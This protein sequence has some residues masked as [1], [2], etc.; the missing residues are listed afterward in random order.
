MT[1]KTERV[2]LIKGD[3]TKWYEQAIFILNPTTQEKMPL[4][5]VQEAEKIINDYNLKREAEKVQNPLILSAYAKVPPKESI[6]SDIRL[7][8]CM[9]IASVAITAIF[10]FNL[11][12]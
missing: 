5:F 1:E 9:A 11:L 7:H 10:V 3:A 8:I 2:I 4:D 12:R 6:F